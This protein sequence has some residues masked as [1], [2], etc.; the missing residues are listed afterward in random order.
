MCR[1]ARLGTSRSGPDRDR[2]LGLWGITRTA[3]HLRGQ[4]RLLLPGW[5][6]H[7]SLLV[8]Q[9]HNGRVVAGPSDLDSDR[10]DWRTDRRASWVAP[11]LT[12]YPDGLQLAQTN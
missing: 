5:L 1:C 7:R 10:L 11:K 4:W 3:A 12:H 6:R 9:R 8:A 2:G